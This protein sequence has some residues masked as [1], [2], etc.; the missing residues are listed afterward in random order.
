MHDFDV[1]MKSGSGSRWLGFL[2]L[3]AVPWAQGGC[4]NP[5]PEGRLYYDRVIQPI[6]TQT[7]VT[8]TSGCHKVDADGNALGNVDLTTFEGVQKRRDILRTYGVYPEPLLLIKAAGPGAHQIPYRGAFLNSEVQHGSGQ[9]LSVQSTAYFELKRWLENGA[10]RDG[11][12]PRKEV[13]SGEGSCSTVVRDEVIQQ[14]GGMTPGLAEFKRD[15]QPTLKSCAAATCHGTPQSDFYLTC[16]DDDNQQL[17]NYAQARNFL[18]DDTRLE[19]SEILIRP[20]D[21]GAGGMSHTGGVHW[22]SRSDMKYSKLLEWARIAKRAPTLNNTPARQFF[23]ARV[24]PVLIQRGCSFEACHSPASFNDFK[25]R[26]GSQ[27]FFSPGALQRNYELSRD[28]FMAIDAVDVRQS[29]IVAKPILGGLPHR[30]G[31]ALQTQG[32]PSDPA[33]C[34]QPYDPATSWAFCTIA[35]WHRLEREQAAAAVSPLNAGSTLPLVW[36]ERPPNNDRLI[37]F[38][39]FRGGADLM[40]GDVGVTAGGGIDTNVSNRRSLLGGCPGVQAGSRTD[41]DVRGPELSPDGARVIFS[42]RL[43]DA[44]GHNLYEVVLAGGACTQ[45]TTDGG[46]MMGPVKIHNIDPLYA[47]MPDARGGAILSVVFASSRGGTFGPRFAG[48]STNL[49]R[50]PRS[51]PAMVEQMTALLGSELSPAWMSDG[52]ITMTTE[53][54]SKDLYQLSGRRINWDRTDYHPLLGQRAKSKVN[55]ADPTMTRDSV[56]YEQA[57]EIRE[58]LNGDFI[59]VFSDVGARGGGG[60]LAVFSRSVGPFEAGRNDPAF[61]KAVRIID[62]AATGRAG[63]TAGAYRAPYEIPNG[64]LL[65]SFAN[66]AT[67]DAG[68]FDYDL[69]IVNRITGARTPLIATAGRSEQEAVLGWKRTTPRQPF[70]NSASLVFGGKTDSSLP[71]DRAVAYFPDAPMVSTLFDSNLRRGRD[72]AFVSPARRIV[73]YKA[74][75]PAGPGN[76]SMVSDERELVGSAAL[77]TDGSVKV[78]VPALAPVYYELQD[79]RG[80]ALFSMS[81]QHQFGPQ[82]MVSLGVRRE[83]YDTACAGCH[84]SITGREVDV[85]VTPDVLTGASQSAAQG[86]TPIRIGP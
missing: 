32:R 80:T 21:P 11:A 86:M 12:L 82:E 3:M 14:L 7:C 67:G 55:L 76:G 73:F 68:S 27:G 44:G 58:G 63:A 64:D 13:P 65:A 30:G 18:E 1:Q 77:L 16:G 28:Q 52:R 10:T 62:P 48:P 22:G 35:E 71:A 37:D 39:T 9:L 31:A 34:P 20:L 81:E 15:V 49:Y 83:L 79:S 57:T 60:A 4:D 2:L 56:G 51:N 74:K 53:K 72:L 59:V 70:I 8:N 43:G 26:A 84:G 23:E 5:Q 47:D 17:F 75:N 42:M 36:V 19:Q 46:Q 41:V 85:Q 69:V 66:V 24:M 33:M 61:V 54:A 45:L 6:L 40:G 38:D 29:R 50:F 25:L 78:N